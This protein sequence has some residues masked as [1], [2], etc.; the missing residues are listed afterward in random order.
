MIGA[1]DIGSRVVTGTTARA[2]PLV[3]GG[4]ERF[5]VVDWPGQITATVFCQGCGWRCRYCHNPGL[6]PFRGVGADTSEREWTWPAVLAWLRDRRGLLDGVVFSGGEPTLQPGLGD[7]VRATRELGFRIGLHTGGPV[8]ETLGAVLPLIDWVGFDYK[9][10]FEEYI[11]VT[12]RVGGDAARQSLRLIRTAG[13]A[14]EVRTTWHPELLSADDLGAM[15]DALVAEGVG[16]WVLQR[17]RPEGCEDPELNAGAAGLGEP[18][19]DGVARRG[20]KVRVR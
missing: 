20:L 12:G 15:A 19:L 13:V 17:F 18:P 7:A 10:P 16:E 3:I 1:N 5:S 4:L 14:L 8:P 9:A 2:R 6:I 11:R